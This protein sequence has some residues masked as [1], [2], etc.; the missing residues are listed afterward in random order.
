M[1]FFVQQFYPTCSSVVYINFAIYLDSLNGIP[2]VI[3]H[4]LP[5]HP[6]VPSSMLTDTLLRAH[7]LLDRELYSVVDLG[8]GNHFTGKCGR[9]V[10]KIMTR[11]ADFT[12]VF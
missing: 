5:P 6:L 11:K 8:N 1:I 2:G 7:K 3:S 12:T 10:S 4:F 9:L